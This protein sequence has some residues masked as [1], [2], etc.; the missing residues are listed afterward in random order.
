MALDT[1]Y[2]YVVVESF[3][4]VET[5]GL[6]GAIHIRPAAKVQDPRQAD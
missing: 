4:P 6:H 3:V 5:T 2:E 1:H